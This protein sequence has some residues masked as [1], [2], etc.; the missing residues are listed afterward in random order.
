M[1]LTKHT[2]HLLISLYRLPKHS[3]CAL[4]KHTLEANSQ[5][6]LQLVKNNNMSPGECYKTKAAYFRCLA[7]IAVA[8]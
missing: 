4:V 8:D 5:L 6:K 1:L 7:A 2:S 3:H